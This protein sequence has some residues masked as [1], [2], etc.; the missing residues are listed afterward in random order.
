MRR[1]VPRVRAIVSIVICI[2]LVLY[3]WLRTDLNITIIIDILIFIPGFIFS[4]FLS[5]IVDIRASNI[6][7]YL[8]VLTSIFIMNVFNESSFALN[9]SIN[10]WEK[11]VIEYMGDNCSTS[12]SI[13]GRAIYDE[14]ENVVYDWH[15]LSYM[16]DGYIIRVEDSLEYKISLEDQ[17]IVK[18]LNEE[19]KV[20]KGKCEEG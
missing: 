18:E 13:Q 5:T 6:L 20:L 7:Y 15:G 16:Y 11:K 10:D 19:H 2:L 14:D 9:L 3:A 12:C 8:I 17:C 1:L 4:Y